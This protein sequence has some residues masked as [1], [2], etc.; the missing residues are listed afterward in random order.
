MPGTQSLTA[1]A[2]VPRVLEG[3]EQSSVSVMVQS[4]EVQVSS[5]IIPRWLRMSDL[6]LLL[7]LET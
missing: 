2:A 7:S 1:G 3:L 4:I 6:M 5:P